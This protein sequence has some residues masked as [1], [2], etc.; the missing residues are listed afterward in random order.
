[1]RASI[2][3][4][5]ASQLTCRSWLGDD[6]LPLMDVNT[7]NPTVVSTLQSWTANLTQT[8]SIAGLRIDGQPI[9]MR[10]RVY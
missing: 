9:L 4:Y 1:V 2:G 8:Y 5:E 6:K 10:H 7:E 3:R